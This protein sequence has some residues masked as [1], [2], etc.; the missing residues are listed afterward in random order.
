MFGA[1]PQDSSCS[2]H[3]YS[4]AEYGVSSSVPSV[5]SLADREQERVGS[6]HIEG[7]TDE[8]GDDDDDDDG[9]GG[10]D[11]DDQDGGDDAGDEEQ[12]VPWRLWHMLLD[13]TGVLVT[14]KEKV[15]GGPVNPKLILS[16]GGHVAG[17]IWRGKGTFLYDRGSL[18]FRSHYMAL[19]GWELTHARPLA[20]G[21]GLTH[22]RSC[23]FQHPNAALLS[24]FVERW[25]PTRTTSTCYGVR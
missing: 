6:L 20:S 9:D 15:K 17:R 14:R 8:K 3:G 24:A 12:L 22:L 16:Y 23:M 10:G 4:H 2:T 19:T 18:K 13:P 1:T 7:E 5:P 11:D 21:S 25:Q